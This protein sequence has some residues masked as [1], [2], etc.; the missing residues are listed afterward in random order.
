VIV[1]E[2]HA[3]QGDRARLLNFA[4]ETDFKQKMVNIKQTFCRRRSPWWK[5]PG[6]VPGHRDKY[7]DFS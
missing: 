7:R 5:K 3:V 6:D 1:S 4:R 2:D